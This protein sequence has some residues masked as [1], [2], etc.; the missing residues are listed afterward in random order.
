MSSTSENISNSILIYSFEFIKNIEF[1]SELKAIVDCANLKTEEQIS[2]YKEVFNRKM[3]LEFSEKVDSFNSF[4][5][6]YI[7]HI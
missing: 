2:A 7:L 1:D 6:D 4:I 5:N 3:T